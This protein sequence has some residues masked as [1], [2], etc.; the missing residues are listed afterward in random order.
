MVA[1]QEGRD[2]KQHWSPANSGDTST[3]GSRVRILCSHPT[4][5]AELLV[6]SDQSRAN[7]ADT[8]GAVLPLMLLRAECYNH[9]KPLFQLH[10]S[11]RSTLCSSLPT[12]ITRHKITY[13]VFQCESFPFPFLKACATRVSFPLFPPQ[14]VNNSCWDLTPKKHQRSEHNPDP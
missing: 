9:P 12:S 13:P 8:S 5:D 10:T 4:N 7:Q 2:V 14:N 6:S 3:K 11:R 1:C